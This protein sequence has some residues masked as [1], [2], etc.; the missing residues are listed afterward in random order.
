MASEEH[1]PGTHQDQREGLK[2][3][4]FF[5]NMENCELFCGLNERKW[6]RGIDKMMKNIKREV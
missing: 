3:K 4:R 6:V 5:L 1:S 2:H